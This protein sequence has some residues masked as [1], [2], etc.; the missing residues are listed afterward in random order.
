MELQFSHIRA[1]IVRAGRKLWE[2]QYVDGSG[3]NISARVSDQRVICTPSLCSKADISAEDLTVVDMDGTQVSGAKPRSSEI[4]LHLEI[5]REVPQ[6]HAVIHCHPPHAMAFA[7]TGRIPQDS[8]VPE[9]E[10]FIGKVAIAPYET[11]GTPEFAATVRPYVRHSNMILLQNHGIVCWADTVSHAEWMVE[12]FDT[13]CGA[14]ILATCLGPLVPIPPE[15]LSELAA[16]RQKL[17]LPT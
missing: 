13:Y 8:L 12:V 2:R 7:L 4:L 17:G 1:E 6:A 11:P 14:L 16:I 10:V 3:G 5:Y 15:K 9:Y